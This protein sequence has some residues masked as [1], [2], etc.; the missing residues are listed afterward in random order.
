MLISKKFTFES[1][2]SI[3]GFNELFKQKIE[4]AHWTAN[5]RGW[6]KED[7]SFEISSRFA[8]LIL[9]PG[10]MNATG[11]V[12]KVKDK[13]IIQCVVG[14]RNI[15]TFLEVGILLAIIFLSSDSLVPVL[16]GVLVYILVKSFFTIL[17]IEKLKSRISQALFL[18]EL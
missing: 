2:R 4:H 12:K 1:I 6:M 9:L 13:T 5:F 3:E 7:Q 11:T 14:Q 10:Q 15:Y 17:F 18:K 16:L 8:R